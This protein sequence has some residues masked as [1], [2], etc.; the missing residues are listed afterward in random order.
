MK[1]KNWYA[2]FMCS[3]YQGLPGFT[4]AATAVISVKSIPADLTASFTTFSMWSLC[5]SR[6][7]GGI[8][9][10]LLKRHLNNLACFTLQITKSYFKWT[11]CCDFRASPNI[12]PSVSTIAHPVSSQD[13]S[14]PNIT[15]FWGAR[16]ILECKHF[17]IT[18]KDMRELHEENNIIKQFW[19]N[20]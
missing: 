18:L 15:Q 10:P 17:L 14:I 5:R 16:C 3:F 9:P 6:A 2:F 20:I 4:V 1:N 8:I 7:I 11:I 13:V 12:F 19:K